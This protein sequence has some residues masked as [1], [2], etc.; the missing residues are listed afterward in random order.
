MIG[1]KSVYFIF[2][3]NYCSG[4]NWARGIRWLTGSGRLGCGGRCRWGCCCGT[5]WLLLQPQKLNLLHGSLQLSLKIPAFRLFWVV[6][7]T[8]FACRLGWNQHA[9]ISNRHVGNTMEYFMHIHLEDYVGQKDISYPNK[10][11]PRPQP[12]SSGQACSS[13]MSNV[14]SVPSTLCFAWTI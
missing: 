2:K 14:R 13:P 9:K 12:V 7:E 5:R 8:R 3:L 6:L 4:R 11:T 1:N 10:D